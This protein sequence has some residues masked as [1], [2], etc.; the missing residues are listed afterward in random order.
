MEDKD[1]I[2]ADLQKK[3]KLME[4]ALE[5]V[6]TFELMMNTKDDLIQNLQNSMELK[7]DQIKTLRDSI[8][9]KTEQIS[10]LD[11]S[12]K[13]KNEKIVTME[14]T[15]RLKEEE[16][17]NIKE[18]SVGKDELAEKNKKIED[19][20]GKL[21]ILKGELETAD[22]DLEILENENET[23]RN[24]ISISSGSKI[25]DSTYLEIPK[26]LILENMKE[27]LMKALH[28]VTIVVPNI[29][30]L[31]ELTLYEVRSS[32]NIKVSTS[33]DITLEEDAEILEELESL[34][35]ISIRMF[36]SS[37]RYVI[38]RDGEELLF[39]VV[40]NAENNHLVLHTR[41]SMHIKSFKSLIM[42]SW[43][44]SRKLD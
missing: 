19:L 12:L 32:V 6:R 5:K 26:K 40:G 28:N 39:A 16:I 31:Q 21:E 37:D 1:Q 8:N 24:Q 14:R 9:L 7:E 2:I 43:L 4:Q 44:R 38:D 42:E 10:T 13:I 20:Q 23:L 27:I 15:I 33:I 3:L 30:D 22:Q 18:N 25:I 36:E 34:D 29:I 17:K 35:N 41:D 11:I